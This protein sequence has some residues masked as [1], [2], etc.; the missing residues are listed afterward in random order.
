MKSTGIEDRRRRGRRRQ[1]RPLSGR[2]RAR[3]R[4]TSERRPAAAVPGG[5]GG[6]VIHGRSSAARG[7]SAPARPSVSRFRVR[8]C[9]AAWKLE[10]RQ[11]ARGGQRRDDPR[12]GQ[13]RARHR[14]QPGSWCFSNEHRARGFPSA[15]VLPL[16]DRRARARDEPQP[17]RSVGRLRDRA[18]G[19]RAVRSGARAAPGPPTRG[20]AV[21]TSHR[22]RHGSKT[23]EGCPRYIGRLFTHRRPLGPSPVWLKDTGC[24]PRGNAADLQRRRHHELRHA[25]TRAIRCTPSTTRSSGREQDHRAAR[26]AG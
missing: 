9:R 20:K 22:R 26:E 6:D 3:R 2:A 7:T 16:A 19:R 11:G 21:A 18:R 8:S 5:R 25:R 23:N 14:P 17:T 15:D 1:P 13:D 24:F 4:Q 12:R 10:Q